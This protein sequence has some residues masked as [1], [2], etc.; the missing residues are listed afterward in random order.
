M[1]LRLACAA[2]GLS[3]ALAACNDQTPTGANNTPDDQPQSPAFA[4]K[5][6]NTTLLTNIPVTGT[7]TDANAI[8]SA[9]TGTLTITKLTLDQTTGDLLASGRITDAA[10][11]VSTFSNVVVESLT[12]NGTCTILDLDIGAIHLNLLGLVID[13]APIHLDNFPSTLQQILNILAQINALLR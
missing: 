11:V 4:K 1:N 10:G 3:L 12:A 13:L 6:Q 9:F 5:S 2:L 7:V 8:T